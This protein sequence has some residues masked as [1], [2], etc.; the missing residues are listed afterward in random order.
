MP[1]YGNKFQG[2]VPQIPIFGYTTN[3]IMAGITQERAREIITK[4]FNQSSGFLT[5][6][7]QQGVLA[8]VLVHELGDS[9]IDSALEA[10]AANPVNGFKAISLLLEFCSEYHKFSKG[11]FL[12]GGGNIRSGEDIL[13]LLLKRQPDVQITAELITAATTADNRTLE[14]LIQHL[15]QKHPSTTISPLIQMAGSFLEAVTGNWNCGGNVLRLLLE[16]RTGNDS[17]I[18]IT[19]AALIN[20]ASNIQC[21]FEVIVV[22]LDHGGPDLE[23]LITEDVIIAAAGNSLWG[24]EIIALLLDREYTIPFSM[25]VISAAE[26]NIWCSEE[27]LALL[28]RHQAFDAEDAD[29]DSSDD[30]DFREDTDAEEPVNLYDLDPDD[31]LSFRVWFGL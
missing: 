15:I 1:T 20:A 14:Q 2:Q 30:G 16:T 28:L 18:P 31:D 26:H 10:A 17:P 12:A 29:A 13:D 5:D 23:E 7:E 27:I 19:Q 25:D 11:T 24:L 8:N 21:G 4:I 22:L 3:L 9:I 6:D